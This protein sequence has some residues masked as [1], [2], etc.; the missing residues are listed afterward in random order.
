MNQRLIM[1]LLVYLML[2]PFLVQAKEVPDKIIYQKDSL[3]QH[4]TVLEN[5]AQKERYIYTD[6]REGIQGGVSLDTPEKLIFEYTQMA[7]VSLAFLDREPRDV[8][9]VGLGSGAMPKYFNRYYPEA[10]IDIVE[11]DPEIV[12]V[13]KKYFYFEENKNMKVHV[14]DG[15][16]FIK[17]NLK[18]YDIIFLDA[19]KGGDIPFHLTTVEF[20]REVKSRLKDG[21]IVIS[22]ILSTFKNKFFDSMVVTYNK[23]FPHLYIFKGRKS[24]SFIF[25]AT[26]I[27]TLKDINEISQK[28]KKIQSSKKMDIDLSWLSTA[29]EYSTEYET[30]AK[31]L[32]DDFAPVNIYQHMKSGS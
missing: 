3:Y 4:I 32:T 19:Y 2:I 26:K 1:T 8:L 18:K 25:V 31:V 14:N 5:T 22:N 15:R 6:K 10:N 23:E 7:F 17:R 30:N 24:Y 21:G 12:N 27:N 29:Y 16:I 28:A 11:I 9:F 20:L 13:A